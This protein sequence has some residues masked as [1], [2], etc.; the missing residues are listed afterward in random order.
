M[1]ARM[2]ARI[3]TIV[4]L[5]LLAGGCGKIA[6]VK[7]QVTRI[8]NAGVLLGRVD[9]D[10]KFAGQV[11][12]AV[13][14]QR[15]ESSIALYR[16]VPVSSEGAF[17]AQVPPGNYLVAAFV[18][19]NRDGRHQPDEPGAFHGA[20]TAVAVAAQGTERVSIRIDANSRPTL[21]GVDVDRTP[22]IATATGTVVP[23]SDPRFDPAN[24]PV[25]LWRP[26]D[27]LASQGAGLYFLQDYDPKRVPVI[28][29]HGIGDGPRRW[30]PAIA[31]LDSTKFQ[32]WVL[33]Y[34]SG[35]RLETISNFFAG[36]VHELR[37]RYGFDEFAVVAHSMGGLVTRS[38]VQRLVAHDAQDAECLRLVITVNSPQGGLPSAASGVEYSPIVIPSWQDVAAGSEFL[39]KLDQ[40]GW[41]ASVPLHMVFSYDGDKNGDGT[42]PLPSQL[43]AVLQSEAVKLHGFQGTH[44]ST[45]ADANFLG[46]M[47]RL[48]AD[49]VAAP[50]PVAAWFDEWLGRWTGPEGTYLDLQRKGA[51][52]AVTIRSLDRLSTYPARAVKDHLE[53]TRDG[54]TEALRATGGTDTGMKWLADRQRCLTVRSGE[55][56][57]R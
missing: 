52:Y 6:A 35:L 1:E 33:Y 29:V 51:A 41:P 21:T 54:R 28:F 34:P 2:L 18:D 30:E 3:A 26:L 17:S 42:V 38:F 32:P 19:L 48:L 16:A 9:T 25:G 39:A 4:A 49:S 40:R 53:F 31:S 37:S 45:L 7:D 43:P 27:F 20:P 44:V 47:N 11:I 14:E 36:A 15:S 46:L 12:A 24:Y 10:E 13:F 50:P 57:C 55:G 22:R 23:L 8:D 5:A 56:Y